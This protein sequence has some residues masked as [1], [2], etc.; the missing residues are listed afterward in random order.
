VLGASESAWR[1]VAIVRIHKDGRGFR[2][3]HRVC[4]AE[5]DSG[6]PLVHARLLR[7]LID[8]MAMRSYHVEVGTDGSYS[9]D[10]GLEAVGFRSTALA[11]PTAANDPGVTDCDGDGNPGATVQ[12]TLPLGARGDVYVAQRGRSVLRGRVVGAGRIE[13]TIDVPVFEQAVLGANPEFLRGAAATRARSDRSRFVL[14]RIADDAT[15]AEL[16]VE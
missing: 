3:S 9:A 11:M 1:S 15:C 10:L 12:L 16:T 6:F 7:G 8:R 4:A 14:R 5:I 2:Q 13:G